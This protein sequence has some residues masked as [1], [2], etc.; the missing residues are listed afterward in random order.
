[1]TFVTEHKISW[2]GATLHLS[3]WHMIV[4][5]EH[6]LRSLWVILLALQ[7]TP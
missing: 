7:I 6:A 5:I 4:L 2:D 3:L 1:M